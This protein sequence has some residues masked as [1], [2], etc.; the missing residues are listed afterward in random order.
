MNQKQDRY[1][2]LIGV[3]KEEAHELLLE[4]E[5][6]LLELEK[7]TDDKELIARVFRAMHTIKGS[8][9]MFGFDEITE[10]AHNI[11][12]V[13]ELVR[14]GDV[15]VTKELIDLTLSACDLIRSMIETDEGDNQIDKKKTAEITKSLREY[16]PGGKKG[17]AEVVLAS[18]KPAVRDNPDKKKV[19]YR[20]RFRPSLDI[21]TRGVNPTLL[22]NELRALGVC[23]IVA[24]ISEIQAL[25]EINPEHCYTYWDIIL[26]TRDDIDTIKDIFI[27]VEDDSEINSQVIDEDGLLDGEVSYKRLGEILV[28]RGDLNQEDVQKVLD[29]QK[30]IG[31]ILVEAGIIDQGKVDSALV[32]QK[33]L[34][35][36]KKG[37]QFS[38]T[39]SSIRVASGKLDKLVDL[40]GELVTVQA[41]LTQTAVFRD[42]DELV[43]LAE[44][45][46]RLI[47]E[48]RDN[49][50]GIRMVPIGTMF[51]RFKRLVRDLSSELGKE[52]EI[53]TEGAE[54]ELD[55]T[56]IE[57][58]NDPLIHLI[59]NTLDHGIELP[60]I[61]ESEGKPRK[62]K[63]FLSAVHSGA[64]VIIQISDDGAGIDH[65]V[66]R[67]KAVDNGLIIQDDEFS[68]KDILGL[69]FAPGF[70]TAKTV[71]SVSGRGVGMDVVKRGIEALRGSIE[72]GSTKGV[73]TKIMISLPLTLA[74]IEGLLVKIAEERFVIPLS[75][76]EECIE[77]T[78]KEVERS[79][80]RHLIKVR[81]QLVPYI[82]L[83]ERFNING[84]SPDIEQVVITGVDD[85]K[86]G[87]AVD[88]VIGEHQTVI[89]SLGRFYSN[90]EGLS[91]AT[92]LGDGSVAM[93][94]DIPNLVRSV[95][96]EENSNV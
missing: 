37:H 6:S 65:E 1:R 22:L 52:V 8:G 38:E 87:L 44:E 48:L 19:T 72:I 5:S 4:L 53:V 73:G 60:E 35:G 41:R 68:E 78:S 67:K 58:L 40:V 10:F 54:T 59:R 49:T 71:S 50:M 79:H 18:P 21:F 66:I 85:C 32:E 39:A 81:E 56:L 15:K 12:T 30:R 89:K 95:E 84:K 33:H 7:K 13:F 3:F 43:L 86:I 25:E 14:N 31:E 74:I 83:R 16:I 20:I 77:L 93:I 46:E 76:V 91:G 9:S 82:K 64:N 27:F 28:E 2:E 69:I 29:E 55:K 11:E 80:G 94:L 26:T 23:E 36:I 61:R 62:G 75:T 17:D 51:S 45:V 42:D 88:H 47:T 90:V 92:I 63:V 57:K 24:Q 70:S 34:K 96:Q